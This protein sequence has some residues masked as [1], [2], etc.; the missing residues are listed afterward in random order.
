M[1]AK[2]EGEATDFTAAYIRRAL[3][4]RLGGHG[5]IDVL[6]K[7]LAGVVIIHRY[8]SEWNGRHV[9]LPVAKLRA[10]GARLQLFWQRTNGRWAPYGGEEQTAFTGSLDACLKEI[11]RDRFGCFWG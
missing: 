8:V 4:A 10:N 2:N 3:E 7:G 9:A 1:A 5:S 6:R 11:D